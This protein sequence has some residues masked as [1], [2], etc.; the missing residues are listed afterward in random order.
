MD[1]INTH[2]H[3]NDFSKQRPLPTSRDRS[4]YSFSRWS[5]ARRS[6]H[7]SRRRTV[8]IHIKME[9]K[10]QVVEREAKKDEIHE[11]DGKSKG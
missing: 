6:H 9:E 7:V 2:R 10:S 5:A 1:L 4:A 11:K 8:K 3:R